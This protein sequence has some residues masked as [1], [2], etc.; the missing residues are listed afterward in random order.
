MVGASD[1]V[2]KWGHIIAKQALR[3]SRRPIYLVNSRRSEVLG[4]QTYARLVDVPGGVDVAVL[5]VPINA[6]S[7]TVEDALASGVK[8]LIVITA[9]LG[10]VDD[11]G[12]ATQREIVARVRDAGSTLIGPNCLG[13]VDNSNEVFLASNAFEP[14]SVALLSQSGNL[15]LELQGWFATYKLGFSRFVSIGNQ[16]DVT[17]IDL[18]ENSI[19]DPHTKAIAIY[20]EDFHDGRGFI[21]AARRA[22][23]VGKPVVVLAAG[24]SASAS[25]S[26]QSHTGALTSDRRIIVEACR[27]AGVSLV[28]TPRELVIALQAGLQP[29]R[30]KGPRVAVVTDGGGHATVASDLLEARGFTV[31]ALSLS[32]QTDLRSQLWAQSTVTNPVDLAGYGEQDPNSYANVVTRLLQDSD[33]DSILI[34][35]YFG[36]YSSPNPFAQGLVEGE[37][38]AAK[39]IAETV[40]SQDKPLCVHTMYPDSPAIAELSAVDI[41]TH[42]A[43]E[44]AVASLVH[45]RNLMLSK[46]P[47]DVDQQPPI[48][49]LTYCDLMPL[50]QL[51]GITTPEMRV[52]HNHEEVIQ[53]ADA[54]AGPFALKANGLLH[55]TDLGGVALNLPDSH[56]LIREFDRMKIEIGASSYSIER[57]IDSTDGVEIIVGITRDRRF[58]AVLLVGL[59]G[60]HTELLRDSVLALAPVDVERAREMLLSLK[61]A[62]LLMGHRGKPS[63][64]VESA[65]LAIATLSRFASAHPEWSEFE[66]NPLLVTPLGATAL[67]VRVSV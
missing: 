31:P 12:R 53:A 42:Y 16:A 10:E 49:R 28:D 29:R 59:G 58:G 2:S 39:K 60:I 38:S 20:V 45:S 3:S 52:V 18:V 50:I 36:G 17:L 8:G 55:K 47:D 25:R 14:G 26:A 27:L 19:D 46:L 5:A 56:S 9:G 30:A 54:F 33:V 7:N 51:E 41:A 67:D 64:D 66:I 32:T 6:L 43:I 65:A 35:G 34:S 57:M 15:A 63:V 11:A 62:S 61:G 4:R 23:E 1:D 40:K 44:D 24:S 21:Q 13:V 48:D 37:I 22:H